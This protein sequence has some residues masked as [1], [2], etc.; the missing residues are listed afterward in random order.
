MIVIWLLLNVL[1]FALTAVLLETSAGVELNPLLGGL[2]LW[3][4]GF[5]KVGMALVVALCLWKMRLRR[6]R[7]MLSFGIGLVVCWNLLVYIG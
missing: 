4:M 2:S 6:L 7:I 1:D 5:M 3:G